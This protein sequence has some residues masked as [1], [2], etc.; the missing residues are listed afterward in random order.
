MRATY[1]R[2]ADFII[3]CKQKANIL[4]TLNASPDATTALLTRRS[5][6][7]NGYACF[8]FMQHV[9]HNCETKTQLAGS[10]L[11]Y[12]ETLNCATQINLNFYMK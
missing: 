2:I 10:S 6:S 7:I 5:I 11:H 8:C 4:I 12:F 9:L 3:A 1:D